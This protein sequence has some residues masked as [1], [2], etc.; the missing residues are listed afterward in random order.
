[1]CAKLFLHQVFLVNS[2]PLKNKWKNDK[3]TA[4]VPAFSGEK[5]TTQV[6]RN[7]HY[8]DEV[9]VLSPSS[10][11][12]QHIFPTARGTASERGKFHNRRRH[13]THQPGMAEML[14]EVKLP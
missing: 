13:T 14:Q 8:V 9:G 6:L 5:M 12:L 7:D 10:P 2:F 11:A 4:Q 3:N 1:M